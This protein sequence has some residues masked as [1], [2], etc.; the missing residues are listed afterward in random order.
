MNDLRRLEKTSANY[1]EIRDAILSVA[2]LTVCSHFREMTRPE[3]AS[4]PSAAQMLVELY[5]GDGLTT[6]RNAVPN[7]P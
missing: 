2:N 3:P 5:N 6:P 4:R 1:E 7:L